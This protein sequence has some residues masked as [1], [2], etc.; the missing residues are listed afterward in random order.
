MSLQITTLITQHKHMLELVTAISG[1]SPEK[2]AAAIA[3][4]LGS[5]GQALTAHLA[6][7]DRDLYP[8]L[9]AAAEKPGAPLSLKTSV[10][11]FFEEMEGIKPKVV[12]FLG[13]WNAG[14]IAAQPAAFR[15]E[16]GALTH[17]L[18]TRISNEEARLYNLYSSY[19]N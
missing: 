9:R 13:K 1:M 10:K 4:K 15:S 14:T 5:L 7:E 16:F 11:T 8:A 17:V 19:V 2:D 18:G 3:T 6:T 12:S